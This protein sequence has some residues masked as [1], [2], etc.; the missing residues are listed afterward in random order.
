M[1]VLTT[2]PLWFQGYDIAF[3][4]IFAIIPLFIAG[5]SYKAKKLTGEKKYATFGA[6]FLLIAIS[7]LLFVLFTFLIRIELITSLLQTFDFVFFLHM[8]LMLTALM[9]LAITILKIKDK[10]V[11]SLLF[12][13][14][15]IFILFSYQYYIKFHIIAFFLLAFLTWQFNSN[16]NKN[17]NI[18]S[19]F[20]F[21]SFFLL[22]CSHIFF[23][24]IRIGPSM[25]VAGEAFQLLGFILLF[26][27]LIRVVTHGRK[28]RK[29]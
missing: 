23:T 14:L 7:Y 16:Y 20:V 15:L 27:V 28:K 2:G 13:L 17:K 24:A 21:I 10:K 1:V 19:K 3:N 22:T 8:V 18:N 11:I 25:H 4:V 12:I 9:L 5:L 6:A 26:L 29:T